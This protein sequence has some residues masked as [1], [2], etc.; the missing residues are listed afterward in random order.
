[1]GDHSLIRSS[2]KPVAAG[3]PQGRVACKSDTCGWRLAAGKASMQVRSLWLVADL[4][5]LPDISMEFVK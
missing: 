2:R 3:Q 4:V 5:Q 1:M